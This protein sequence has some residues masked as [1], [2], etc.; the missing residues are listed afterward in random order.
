M[1]FELHNVQVFWQGSNI[2]VNM[3]QA[4]SVWLSLNF[5]QNENKK[6]TTKP[7]Q[8]LKSVFEKCM[9]VFLFPISSIVSSQTGTRVG[10]VVG[11]LNT[12]Y[13]GCR[14]NGSSRRTQMEKQTN[15]RMLPSTLYLLAWLCCTV[16]KT[17][18]ISQIGLLDLE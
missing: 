15:R 16:D 2:H 8:T 7:V 10:T 5:N 11:F 3:S 4:E 18:V 12:K 6:E 9:Y 17:Y 1:N 13:Q 14:S